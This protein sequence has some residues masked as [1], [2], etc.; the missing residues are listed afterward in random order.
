MKDL[1]SII[2]PVYNV[3]KYLT[4]CVNSL[5]NQ[6]YEEVEIILINDGSPDQCP[7][8]CDEFA[9]NYENI[10]VVH[11][12][13]AGL[14]AARNSGI[15][16][17]KGKYLTFVDSDDYINNELLNILKNHIDEN[18]VLLSMCSYLKVNDSTDVSEIVIPN[19]NLKLVN[20]YQ[21]MEMLL[22]DQS[23]CTAWG[24]LYNKDL[25][26][27]IRYP[28]D[29]IMEDMFV[30]PELFRKAKLIA[31]DSQQL[32][33]YNQEGFSITRSNFNYKKLDMIEATKLWTQTTELY[34]P[35]LI[36]KALMHYF[37]TI[38]NTC[39]FLANS[40]DEFRISKYKALKKEILNNF[41]QIINS[42]FTRRNDK[43][44]VILMKLG[45]FP[46][47]S[48]LRSRESL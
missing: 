9:N 15:D 46:F 38:L 13:N 25:F 18:S 41:K 43:I 33:F 20:D 45:F 2:V 44:K 47:V 35:K 27:N 12:K 10:N 32:Y 37:S 3:E 48:K 30:I 14:S 31:I 29:K 28:T 34:Y 4:R 6:T 42:K 21:A 26:K 5:I 40:N 17:A 16:I 39:F 8:I 1:I 7:K 22:D 24:K 11:Q 36:N 19:K 23:K